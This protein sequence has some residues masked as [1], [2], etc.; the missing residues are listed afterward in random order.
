MSYKD[1]EKDKARLKE[2]YK[3][4]EALVKQ[5]GKDFYAANKEKVLSQ[6]QEKREELIVACKEWKINNKDKIKAYKS[7]NKDKAIIQNKKDKAKARENLSDWYVITLFKKQTG[8]S[9]ADI[10]QNP[11]L[12]EAF[13]DKIRL[14]RMLK[15]FNKSIK[16]KNKL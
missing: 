14:K 12:L 1:K 13:K 16:L 9:T 5:R 15:Q 8:A 11:E 10:K 6:H 4:N 2:Y 7:Q 3:N